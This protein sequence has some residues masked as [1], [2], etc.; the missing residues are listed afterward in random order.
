[1]LDNFDHSGYSDHTVRLMKTVEDLYRE[2]HDM[3]ETIN[4]ETIDFKNESGDE[5]ECWKTHESTKIRLKQIHEILEEH[6]ILDE[7]VSDLQFKLIT[8]CVHGEKL[9]GVCNACSDV[10]HPYRMIKSQ[11]DDW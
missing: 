9:D 10:M 6:E 8:E 11:R 4:T 5:Y 3:Q 7:A 1:M 2:Q